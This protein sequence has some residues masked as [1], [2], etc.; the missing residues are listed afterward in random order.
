MSVT[1]LG[2][3]PMDPRMV[4]CG[5]SGVSFQRAYPDSAVTKAFGAIAQKMADART[6]RMRS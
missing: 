6:P 4:A 2:R 1:F 5:D 3:I